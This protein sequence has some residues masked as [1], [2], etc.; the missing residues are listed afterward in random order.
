M[1]Y[2]T[3]VR[4]GNIRVM[5][6]PLVNRRPSLSRIKKMLKWAKYIWAITSKQLLC[7]GN[8]EREMG[9]MM[10]LLIFLWGVAGWI[11]MVNRLAAVEI[12]WKSHSKSE[13]CHQYIFFQN[14]D[15]Q[16]RV[17][18]LPLGGGQGA[19]GEP[20]QAWGPDLGIEPMIFLL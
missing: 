4:R 12:L 20:M 8:R 1:W 18:N 15:L 11:N 6:C 9:R 7:V 17:N 3:P 19:W 2:I 13:Q 16:F 14:L 5:N 10:L